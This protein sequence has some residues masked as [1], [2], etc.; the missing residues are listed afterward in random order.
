MPLYLNTFFMFILNTV[1]H[2]LLLFN[3]IFIFIYSSFMLKFNDFQ[4]H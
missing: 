4:S 2:F 3:K 1:I